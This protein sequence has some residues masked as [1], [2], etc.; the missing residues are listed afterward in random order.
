VYV[1]VRVFVDRPCLDHVLH[2]EIDPKLWPLTHHIKDKPCCFRL[3]VVVTGK[4]EQRQKSLHARMGTVL[5]STYLE[6]RE[7]DVAVIKA[8][9]LTQSAVSRSVQKNELSHKS[10]QEVAFIITLS[11][12]P[13]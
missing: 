11:Q 8:N 13:K 10:A 4:Y 9:G 5:F 12:A 3:V 7:D 6:Q 1:C 2:N